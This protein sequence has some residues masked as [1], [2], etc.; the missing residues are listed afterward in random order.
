MNKQQRSIL[1]GRKLVDKFRNDFSSMGKGVRGLKRK[2]MPV[3]LSALGFE[4]LSQFF[5][6]NAAMNYAELKRCYILTGICDF[7]AHRNPCLTVRTGKYKDKHAEVCLPNHHWDI[8][9]HVFYYYYKHENKRPV[10]CC[11][12][13]SELN[14][15]EFDITWSMQL[16]GT[17][18]QV[19]LLKS[20]LK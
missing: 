11:L 9:W 5:D 17:P 10:D 18:E 13:W 8:P 2:D 15:P 3:R 1:Q 20:R 12:S 14:E 7:C 19:E 16:G 6:L 4:T